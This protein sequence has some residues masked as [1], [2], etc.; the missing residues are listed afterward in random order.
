V[1][2]QLGLRVLLALLF[3]LA[4]TVVPELAR[5]RA[6]AARGASTGRSVRVQSSSFSE[7]NT[8][9]ETVA[10]VA[11]SIEG[12]SLAERAPETLTWEE[13]AV[14]VNDQ[15]QKESVNGW[16]YIISGSLALVGGQ[17]GQG[18]AQDAFE[19]GI[20]TVFQSIGIASI[21]YGGYTWAIGGEDRHLYDV[22]SATTE[23]KS[24]DKTAVVR[25]YYR[26]KAERE[27]R[28]RLVR[29]VTHGLIATLNLYNASQQDNGPVRNALF[30]VGGINLLACV[31][32]SF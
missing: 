22:L 25:E 19:K 3:V 5:A 28:E 26:A 15:T 18:L 7:A 11:P 12:Q 14:R 24:K 16:S 27:K 4:T 32:F 23:L 13:F 2:G 17:V 1:A 20:Y 31:S 30:F 21:G 8:P 6:G 9:A 10:P 29:A